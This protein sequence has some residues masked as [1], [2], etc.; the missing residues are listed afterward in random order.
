MFNAFEYD[1]YFTNTMV[2]RL[3]R[4][5]V[6][7]YLEPKIAPGTAVLEFNCGTGED[8]VWLA[9]QGCPVLAT[10]LS[11]E[12]VAATAEKARAANLDNRVQTKVLDL[13]TLCAQDIGETFDLVFSNFGGLNCLC[14]D[15]MQQLGA[16]LPQLLRPGGYF[17]AVLMGRFCAWET[18]YFLLKGRGRDALR[19]LGGGPVNARL[20]E[21]FSIRT[22]YYSPAEVRRFFPELCVRS[23]QPVGFWLPPS[24]LNPWFSRRK[25][26][27]NPL[28]YLE[29]K[30]RGRLWA[31]AA[32]HF[33]A[34]FQRV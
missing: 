20:S 2:G 1:E 24:Y 15:D 9:R 8:A 14:P 22:W 16:E 29:Q 13:R 30:S 27:L 17:V 31:W 33:M 11:A 21:Q 19:R 7:N 18:L 10:D 23:I 26:L 3:Q 6:H 32:D 4:A 28:N 34:I 5:V 25:A 12:M